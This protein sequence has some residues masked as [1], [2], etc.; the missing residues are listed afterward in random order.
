MD[1][2][3]LEQEDYGVKGLLLWTGTDERYR[4]A[5]G[6]WVFGVWGTSV[7]TNNYSWNFY[8]QS[9]FFQDSLKDPSSFQDYSE[10]WW[11]ELGVDG[12]GC[13]SH[14]HPTSTWGP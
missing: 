9:I 10:L 8:F 12:V 6:P 3:T 5:S 7:S 2:V 11:V 14:R 1:S 13:G 4:H